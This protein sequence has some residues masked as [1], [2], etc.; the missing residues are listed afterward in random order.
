[1]KILN[2]FLAYSEK[3]GESQMDILIRKQL[4]FLAQRYRDY[5]TIITAPAMFLNYPM[6]SL[7]LSFLGN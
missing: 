2:T 4:E 5:N 7:S 1:M 6:M 3:F